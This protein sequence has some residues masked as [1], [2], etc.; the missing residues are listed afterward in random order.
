MTHADRAFTSCR[1]QQLL[2]LMVAAGLEVADVVVAVGAVAASTAVAAVVVGDTGAA[3]T[4]GLPHV[5]ADTHQQP[6]S[7]FTLTTCGTI[8]L[9]V[10]AFKQYSI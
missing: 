3:V 9:L 2:P 7:I 1:C 4:T 10:N 5:S 6:V 8:L